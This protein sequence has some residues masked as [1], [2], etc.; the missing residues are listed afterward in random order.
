MNKGKKEK[1]NA[2]TEAISLKCLSQTQK[3]HTLGLFLSPK[4]VVLSHYPSAPTGL[5]D[6]CALE[7]LAS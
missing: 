7:Q 5:L 1:I 4:S 3:W 6:N 2:F